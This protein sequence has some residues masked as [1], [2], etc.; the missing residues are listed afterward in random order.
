M[1]AVLFWTFFSLQI[2]AEAQQCE[3]QKSDMDYTGM[4]GPTRDQGAVGWCYAYTAADLITFHLRNTGDLKGGQIS[5]SGLSLQSNEFNRLTSIGRLN[6]LS[7]NPSRYEA[8]AEDRWHRYEDLSQQL[9]E[10]KQKLHRQRP[11]LKE[12]LIRADAQNDGREFEKAKLAELA[13]L[14]RDPL[15]RRIKTQLEVVGSEAMHIDNLRR[16]V[17]VSGGAYLELQGGQ[18]K[19]ALEKGLANGMCLESRLPSDDSL[20]SENFTKMLN[21]AASSKQG[22]TY[23]KAGK[24]QVFSYLTDPAVRALSNQDPNYCRYYKDLMAQVFQLHQAS[25][26]AL[27][28]SPSPVDQALAEACQLRPEVL[29]TIHSGLFSINES[30]QNKKNKLDEVLKS[31]RPLEVNLLAHHFEMEGEGLAAAKQ[32]PKFRRTSHSVVIAGQVTDCETGKESYIVRNSWGP[33]G[34]ERKRLAYRSLSPKDPREVELKSE[35]QKK[36]KV[37]I[38]GDKTNMLACLNQART[39]HQQARSQ[40]NAAPFTCDENGNF[41]FDKTRFA[42]VVEGYTYVE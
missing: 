38:H 4:M 42:E 8:E 2:S 28:A 22:K 10:R 3:A 1:L 41:L 26:D 36:V 35:M 27:V 25:V 30:T 32:D 12:G 20:A 31:G 29:P 23:T 33:K 18:A 6:A 5:A 7:L 16:G 9:D 24:R 21:Q 14:N 19:W 39:D 11:D 40:I 13:Y 15:Y 17:E 37:C 34:C